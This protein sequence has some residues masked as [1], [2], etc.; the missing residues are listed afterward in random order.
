VDAYEVSLAVAFQPPLSIAKQQQA[1]ECL[2]TLTP[3]QLEVTN[4]LCSV[5]LAVQADD[6]EAARN[7]AEF[8]VARALSTA[9]H[10]MITAPIKTESV[11][12]AV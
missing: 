12:P 5:R 9:G 4:A 11:R 10:T 7:D 3:V 2:E 8:A 6:S 1:I